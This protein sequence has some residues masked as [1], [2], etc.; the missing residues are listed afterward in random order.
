MAKKAKSE[1]RVGNPLGEK[2]PSDSCI[3]FGESIPYTTYDDV[4]KDSGVT[5]KWRSLLGL[6]VQSFA[7]ELEG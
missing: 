6:Q 1:E 5:S 4:L 3:D 2:D 7:Y